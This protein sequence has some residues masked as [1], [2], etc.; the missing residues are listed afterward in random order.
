MNNRMTTIANRLKTEAMFLGITKMMMI[1]SSWFKTISTSISTWRKEF[2]FF[3]SFIH[4]IFCVRFLWIKMI[5]NPTIF[6][7][8]FS[9]ICFIFSRNF[10]YYFFS[11]FALIVFSYAFCCFW[12]LYIFASILPIAYFTIRLMSIFFSFAFVKLRDRSCF[13]AHTA[14]FSFHKVQKSQLLGMCQHK[15]KINLSEFR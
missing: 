8:F 10:S 1:L 11:V 2:S 15:N 12:S 5:T 4:N 3:D 7:K 14:M 9:M 6:A 13:F